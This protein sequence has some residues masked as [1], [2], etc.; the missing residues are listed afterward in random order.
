MTR[1]FL[2]P[3]CI[4]VVIFE[5]AGVW[6]FFIGFILAIYFVGQLL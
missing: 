2:Y 1:W 6:I 4:L 5:L 3:F